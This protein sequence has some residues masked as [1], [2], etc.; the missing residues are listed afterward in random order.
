MIHVHTVCC[1]WPL[2]ACFA[3]LFRAA[4]HKVLSCWQSVCFQEMVSPH[5]CMPMMHN[6]PGSSRTVSYLNADVLHFSSVHV[7]IRSPGCVFRFLKQKQFEY[8]VCSQLLDG[9]WFSL[10]FSWLFDKKW[11]EHLYIG[12]EQQWNLCATEILR[13]TVHRPQTQYIIC[14]TDAQCCLCCPIS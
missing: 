13:I 5:T 10:E 6:R 2:F 8:Y 1:R 12:F 9:I 3:I 7:I 14:K 4:P 11:S